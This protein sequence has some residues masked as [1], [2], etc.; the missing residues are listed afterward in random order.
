MPS[1]FKVP[2]DIDL[3]IRL[4]QKILRFCDW[5]WTNYVNKMSRLYQMPTKKLEEAQKAERLDQYDRKFLL[6]Q[7]MMSQLDSGSLKGNYAYILDS[8]SHQVWLV[9][10]NSAHAGN[11]RIFNR[12][13]LIRFRGDGFSLTRQ[14]PY[15]IGSGNSCFKPERCA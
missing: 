2:N 7:K 10:P 14:L 8:E 11:T 12:E 15:D 6:I 5:R 3:V 1:L 9:I 13:K 4:K